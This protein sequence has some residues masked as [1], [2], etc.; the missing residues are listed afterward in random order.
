MSIFTWLPRMICQEGQDYPPSYFC[1]TKK[2]TL[3]FARTQMLPTFRRFPKQCSDFLKQKGSS[4]VLSL[5]SRRFFVAL[6]WR[7]P[8]WTCYQMGLFDCHCPLTKEGSAKDRTRGGWVKSAFV[9]FHPPTRYSD[10]YI[11]PSIQLKFQQPK[12]P[13]LLLKLICSRKICTLNYFAP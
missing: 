8:H 11:E 2:F 13:F 1:L 3:F 7:T 10:C 9:L 4:I 6:A 5:K 12:Y